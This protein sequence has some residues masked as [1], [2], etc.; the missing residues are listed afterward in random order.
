MA[1]S[2]IRPELGRQDWSP[3][4]RGGQAFGQ[5]VG[6]GLAQLGAG[7]GQAIQ[8]HREKKQD[9]ADFEEFRKFSENLGLAPDEASVAWKTGGKQGAWQWAQGAKQ[10][11]DQ[12]RDFGIALNALGTAYPATESGENQFSIP[13]YLQ[14]FSDLGGQDQKVAMSVLQMGDRFGMI[15]KEIGAKER[16]DIEQ[17]KA[18]T[19]E[20][21]A[22]AEKTKAETQEILGKKDAPPE[23]S[24]YEKTMAQEMAKEAVEWAT[25]GRSVAVSNWARLD[26]ATEALKSGQVK[27]GTLGEK[28]IPFADVRRGLVNPNLEN[29]ID[30]VRGV[31]FQSLKPILGGNFSKA[32]ADN[33]VA[34]Y[35]NP[36]LDRATNYARL[37]MLTD[38]MKLMIDAK[39]E[40][41]NYYHSHGESM[42]G[43]K[44]R[45]AESIKAELENVPIIETGEGEEKKPWIIRSPRRNR[46]G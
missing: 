42:E 34:T 27:S 26:K 13:A 36:K 7:I 10:S 19:A 28:M 24:Q 43:Y 31:V 15:P 2:P 23:P 11:L 14:G 3:I 30:E 8:Q 16:A 35:V 41:F 1:M 29:L 46:N 39:E 44:G 38:G 4:A 17:T 33:L 6:Q 12:K 21:R 9:K 18:E 22:K 45:S 25:Q 32:E 20:T 40:S 5:G 37:R